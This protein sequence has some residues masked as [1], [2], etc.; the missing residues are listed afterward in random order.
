MAES[1]TFSWGG[2]INRSSGKLDMVERI[3][4][5]VFGLIMVLTF[6]CTMSAATGGR[7]E[8]RTVLW[9]ALGCNVA[10]G[11]IDA[12]IYIFSV[13]M[14]RGEALDTLRHIRKAKS[15]EEA[16]E[17]IKDIMPTLLGNL[18]KSEHVDQLRAEINKL[19]E[20]PSTAIFTWN[21]FLGAVKIFL[22]VFISTFPVTIPFIFIQDVYLAL[23]IS[24][25]IALVLL[26][27][28]GYYF[29][30]QT[31]YKSFVTGL[32]V[33]S[34]GVLLVAMTIALGG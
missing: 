7:E 29:G 3:N 6:T 32:A 4:E 23:R 34:I 26:F 14:Y 22:L 18:M 33:M 16:N 30:K 11:I 31:R 10:W 8:V 20:P 19:P 9:A 1:K 13:L 15:D 25:G 5:V 21:D 24:N 28:T 27:I 17:A 2:L 12:F